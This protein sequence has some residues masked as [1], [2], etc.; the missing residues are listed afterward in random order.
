MS[1]LAVNLNTPVGTISM[2]DA[3]KKMISRP[4]QTKGD[5]VKLAQTLG[6]CGESDDWCYYHSFKAG[7]PKTTNLFGREFSQAQ[8]GTCY[9]GPDK[10]NDISINLDP[11][12]SPDGLPL[13]ITPSASGTTAEQRYLA[14]TR[15]LI[16]RS[17]AQVQKQIKVDTKKNEA[18]EVALQVLQSAIEKGQTFEQAKADYQKSLTEAKKDQLAAAHAQQVARVQKDLDT[19]DSKQELKKEILLGKDAVLTERDTEVNRKE[20]EAQNIQNKI[21]K[22]GQNILDYQRQFNQK[23]KLVQ[24]LMVTLFVLTIFVFLMFTY[25]GVK[26]ARGTN[27]NTQ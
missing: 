9:M 18:S 23:S 8:P 22:T 5:C 19:Y 15:Q 11:T 13:Y 3:A 12:T 26:L 4:A 14:T 2:A 16:K 20:N 10:A 21:L 25:Y 24:I 17:Q 1:I 7:A 6:A 27:S